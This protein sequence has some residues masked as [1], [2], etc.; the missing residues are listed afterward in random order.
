MS[1]E[2]GELERTLGFLEAMTLGGGTMIGAGIFIL[3]GIAARNAG[4]A[5]SISYAIAGFVALLAALSLSELATGMPIAGGSYHYVN[6]ALG[7][8]FGAIVGWGMWTGL[9]FASAFY[10]VGFGQY[11]VGPIPGLDGRAFVVILGLVGLALLVG[12][13]YYGTDQSSALQNVMIGA[14]TAVVLVFVAVG[15]LFIDTAN[16]EPFAPTGPT[17]IVAT[18][19]I[20]FVSF[21]GF[22]IIATVAGEIENPSR[23]IPLSMILSVVSVT[24]LYVLVMLVS[25]GVVPIDVLG[26]SPIPVSEVAEVSMGAL[27]VVGIAFAA[28]VAAISSSNSSILAASRVIYAMGRDGLVSDWFNESHDRFYTPHRAIL[29][30]GG[31]TALLIALGLRVE[32]IIALLAEAASFS[33]LVAYLLVHVALVV[34]R[35]ADP[36]EYDPSF[37]LPGVLYPAV[38]ILGGLLTVVVITQMAPLVIAIGSAIIGVGVAWYFA[39]ARGRTVDEGLFWDAFGE[40]PAEPYRVVVPIANPSTQHGLLRLAAASAHANVERGTPELVVANVIEG[41][42][43]SPVRN[44]EADRVDHQRELLENARDVAEAVDV[45]LRTRA[46]VAPDVGAAILEVVGEEDADQLLIGWDGT[47]GSGEHVF[48]HTIDP[49]VKRAGCDVSL[50]DLERDAAGTTVALVAPGPNAPAVAARAAEFATLDGSRPTLAYVQPPGA[51]GGDESVE[52]DRAVVDE[53]AAS[54]GLDVGEYDVDVVVAEDVAAAAVEAI[55]GFD[56]VCI[57]LS[58]RADDSGIPFGPITE[59]VAR[60]ASGNVA[61]IRGSR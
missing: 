35:R 9:M 38:P 23:T 13:N 17:G 58:R 43:D 46:I 54:A 55:D 28:V 18:T 22:E 16:L 27:G 2:G 50:V 30:T 53:I 51:E 33:F 19:G 52:R 57:G 12:V 61:L 25:T 6:R 24:L 1:G 20:V 48:G 32:T 10:M 41:R 47:V 60:E 4:P 59:R 44:L 21:L 39:Y 15:L 3:P 14:E 31:V 29:A 45:D 49:V 37:E 40:P 34:F 7:G 5:S 42:R 11:L 36:D 26:E 56:T 8:L